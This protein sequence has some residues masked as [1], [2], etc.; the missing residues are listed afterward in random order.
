MSKATLSMV[1]KILA[2][3]LLAEGFIAVGIHPGWVRP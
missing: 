2:T 3:D 1:T